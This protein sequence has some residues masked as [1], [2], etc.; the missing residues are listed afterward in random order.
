MIVLFLRSLPAS[1]PLLCQADRAHPERDSFQGR[2]ADGKPRLKLQ[3]SVFVGWR[4]WQV[5]GLFTQFF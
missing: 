3:H 1:V 4:L 2:G 5:C